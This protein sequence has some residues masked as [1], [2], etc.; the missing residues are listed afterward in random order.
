MRGREARDGLFIGGIMT[1]TFVGADRVCLPGGG[2][3]DTFVGA[4][5]VNYPPGG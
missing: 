5:I 2:M 3:T 1:D 4:H